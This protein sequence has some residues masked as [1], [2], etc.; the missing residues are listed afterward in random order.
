MHGA[1][2]GK[3]RR[4]T[5]VRYHGKGRGSVEKRDFC[6]IRIVLYEKDEETFFEELAEGKCPPGLAYLI[7]ARLSEK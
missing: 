7:R 6:Q 4:Y 3:T 1:L 2:I 5:G